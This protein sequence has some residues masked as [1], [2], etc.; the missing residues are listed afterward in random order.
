MSEARNKRRFEKNH[1]DK[2]APPQGNRIPILGYRLER[3]ELNLFKDG[4]P[5]ALDFLAP[6]GFRLHS[7]VPD[8][9]SH[10]I[11]RPTMAT[12]VFESLMPQNFAIMRPGQAPVVDNGQEADAPVAPTSPLKTNGVD[13]SAA[14]D[15]VDKMKNNGGN[16]GG[17]SQG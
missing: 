5:Q 9:P 13:L 4:G 1:R 3:H 7:I 10:I 14:N 12:Y 17:E 2:E 16:D 8:V 11:G 6:V 15:A